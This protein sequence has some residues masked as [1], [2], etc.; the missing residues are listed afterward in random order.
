MRQSLVI[1]EYQE[2]D[3]KGVFLLEEAIY[4]SP[5]DE[6]VW[7]WKFESGP[8]KPAKIYVAESDGLIAGLR[9]FIIEELKVM[10]K[11]WTS[12]LGVD[13]MVHPNF[14]RFGIAANMAQEGFV[15]MENERMP[16]LL[17]FPNEVAFKV[18]SRKRPYW[19]HICTVPLLAKPLD[20][21]SIL[22]AYIKNN[23]LRWLVKLPAKAMF[24]V[25]SRGSLHKANSLMV[26]QTD[27]FD[28]RFDDFWQAASEQYNIGLVRDRK[29]LN[30]RFIDKPGGEYSIFSAE[31]D[32]GVLGYIVLKNAEM[33]GLSLGLI[34]DILTLGQDDVI[35]SLLAKAIEHFND[36]KRSVVGCVMLKHSPYFKALRRAGFIPVP[37]LLSPKKF[38]FGVQVK[39]TVL[40]DEVV[41]NEVNWF[42][43]W[44][45][46]DLA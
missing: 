10:D 8:V 33:S 45:D 42:L 41:N 32:S 14:R 17:S 4:G 43:T 19:R 9:A 36:Q 7:R 34:V 23:F 16:I 35:D 40:S 27:S 13:T 46:T 38:Y 6:Q 39:P 26:K 29:F 30:W 3:K 37:K 44:G 5:F 15:R 1:R 11:V 25:L 28:S 18:Y 2:S 31:K 12:G 20:T 24:K 22:R 21:N